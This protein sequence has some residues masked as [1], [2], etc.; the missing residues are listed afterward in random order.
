MNQKKLLSLF[1]LKWNPFSP[2]LPTE[3][4]IKSQVFDHFCWKVEGLAL[5][6]G[7]AMITGDPGLGK[8]ITMRALCE[9]LS[10]LR[11]ITVGEI[12]RPQSGVGDFYR[13]MGTLFGIELRGNNRWGGFRLMRERWKTHIDSTL[14][15]P[16]VLID[17]AQEM[18][19][20]VLSEL[21]LMMSH[22]FDSQLLL[23]VI[24]AGDNRLIERLRLQEL[25]P[26]GT[27]IRTRLHLETKT[28]NELVVFLKESCK[29][30]GNEQ[31]MTE[32]LM[33]TLAEH[34]A[35]NPRILMTLSHELLSL[36]AKK[37]IHQLTA[38]LYFEAYPQAGP[39]GP[40]KGGR[41]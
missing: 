29:R 38:S 26:L 3:A 5:D 1:G 31:L 21:R 24:L 16:V 25:V 40:R 22:H 33:E 2:D 13:E 18:P 41:H 34:S 4:I 27:R 9:H 6:G 14:L 12:I 20:Q 37:E 39:P 19:S 36:G 35:G 11:E 32:E 8:S 23:T 28:K 17:E 30:A 15:R 10:K 7:F